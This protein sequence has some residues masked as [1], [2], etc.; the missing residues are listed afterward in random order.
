MR[1]ISRPEANSLN[2]LG[3]TAR[4]IKRCKDPSTK[5][6]SSTELASY[7]GGNCDLHF[8]QQERGGG[9]DELPGEKEKKR[10][11]HISKTRRSIIKR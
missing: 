1:R 4:G 5:A 11:D 6:S 2:S 9:K 8:E 10:L 7:G 3:G